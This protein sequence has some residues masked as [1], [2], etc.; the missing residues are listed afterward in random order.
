MKRSL[1]WLLVL[2]CVLLVTP[3]LLA[4][5]KNARVCNDAARISA[6][7]L[8]AQSGAAIVEAGWKT[9]VNEANMLANRIYAR[10]GGAKAARSAARDLRMHVRMMRKEALAGNAAEARRHAAE[11]IPFAHTLSGWACD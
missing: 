5:P 2:S 11:A 4:K 1:R 6:L 9:T 10:S 7:L 3:S 8:D